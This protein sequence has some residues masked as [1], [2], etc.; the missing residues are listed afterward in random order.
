M[1]T[2]KEQRRVGR[3]RVQSSVPARSFNYGIYSSSGEMRIIINSFE[4]F[5]L[6]SERCNMT[7]RNKRSNREVALPFT[8]HFLRRGGGSSAFHFLSYCYPAIL[9]CAEIQTLDSWARTP[10][11]TSALCRP[12]ELLCST[13]FRPSQLTPFV[14]SLA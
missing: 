13:W 9:V 8:D 5:C 4:R 7:S 12:P 1:A 14:K 10:N 3:S 6:T 11:A 2:R